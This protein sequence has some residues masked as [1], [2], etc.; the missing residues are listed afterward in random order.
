MSNFKN[1][2][3]SKSVSG[4]VWFKKKSIFNV[5]WWFSISQQNIYFEVNFYVIT[6]L[7][8]HYNFRIFYYSN[9]GFFSRLFVFYKLYYILKSSDHK[10]KEYWEILL[11]KK[12]IK[13]IISYPVYSLGNTHNTAI[14]R[15]YLPET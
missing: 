1:V 11:H 7:K 10:I 9:E 2:L 5:L 12:T 8:L 3:Y 4:T 13:Y 14:L 15:S 6:S